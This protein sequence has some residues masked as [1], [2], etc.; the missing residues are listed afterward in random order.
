MDKNSLH[1]VLG[2]GQVGPLVVDRLLEKGARVR[3]VRRSSQAIAARPGVE[4]VSADVRDPEAAANAMRGA[5]VVYN[6]TN[7]RY[8]QWPEVLPALARGI[9]A[10]AARNGA[11]L[12][13]LD[14]L[15]MYGDTARM[16]EE[17]EL[18]P[19]SKKGALRVENQRTLLDAHERGDVR[20][21]IARAAD[22]FGPGVSDQ[23]AFGKLFFTRVLR[24]RSAL[25][26][27]NPDEVHTYSYVP[28][29][30]AGL[31]AI[32]ERE[33]AFGKVWMLPAPPAETTR[34]VVARFARAL[35]T[36][37][38]TTRIPLFVLRT[39]GL[40]DSIIRETVEMTYQFRQ[41]FVLDDARFRATF[42]WGATP[43]DEAIAASIAWGRVRYGKGGA[44]A[45]V[46]PST[47]RAAAM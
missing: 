30:A 12:V 4:L 13:V 9:L 33:D 23:S 24:G 18:S 25:C 8:D 7:P 14:C 36:D 29:V 3:V 20:V 1:V 39:A 16:N 31:V 34:A 15:Y 37:L 46:A 28:D 6:C 38:S 32:G 26:L 35:G 45:S 17:S 19:R 44:P 10:G 22:F 27:G 41:P 42:G 5:S 40:F 43:W 2:A 47:S 11:R 21:A